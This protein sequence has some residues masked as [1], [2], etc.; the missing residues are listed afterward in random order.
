MTL[1]QKINAMRCHHCNYTH[2]IPTACENCKHPDLIFL[3]Q[4]TEQIEESINALF[5]KYRII[6]LDSDTMQHKGK[7]QTTLQQIHNNEIDIIR[8]TQSR[9]VYHL[10]DRIFFAMNF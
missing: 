10:L 4:G 1:H 2:N 9:L 3:G 7:L 8:G 5:N 6:H